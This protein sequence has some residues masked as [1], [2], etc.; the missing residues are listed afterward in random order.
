MRAPGESDTSIW[1]V[2]HEKLRKFPKRTCIWNKRSLK[3]LDNMLFE[4]GD[5]TY[6]FD[7]DPSLSFLESCRSFV[8]L[9]SYVNGPQ[10]FVCNTLM[11][12]IIVFRGRHMRGSMLVFINFRAVYQ[13]CPFILG[14]KAS[15]DR[16]SL[17]G[18]VS[19]YKLSMSKIESQSCFCSLLSSRAYLG[20]EGISN[21]EFRYVSKSGY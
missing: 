1:S 5:I 6:Q 10:H 20:E 16:N 8:C 9:R 4:S 21:D 11:R 7:C 15:D 19:S 14:T 12:R 2:L 18:R 3:R 17:G 13:H